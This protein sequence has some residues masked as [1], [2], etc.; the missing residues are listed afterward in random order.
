MKYFEDGIKKMFVLSVVCR[1]CVLN[2]LSACV[3][4]AEIRIP[5]SA[6]SRMRYVIDIRTIR[7][8]INTKPLYG[9][10][11]SIWAASSSS[12]S[13]AQIDA[14]DIL[15]LSPAPV[16]TTNSSIAASDVTV[17]H[18]THYYFVL[19][20]SKSELCAKAQPK[21][22]ISSTRMGGKRNQK[23]FW[24]W[25]KFEDISPLWQTSALASVFHHPFFY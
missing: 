4:W 9:Y 25:I 3:W 12:A 23:G 21:W 22:Q 10:L 6:A 18:N 17:M 20:I 16:T 5:N 7:C 15:Q 14:Q 8:D 11:L 19:K 1:I 24:N 13:N 2:C